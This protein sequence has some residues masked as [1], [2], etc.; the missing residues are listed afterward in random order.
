MRKTEDRA[1]EVADTIERFVDGI[2]GRWDW[3]DFML[4]GRSS[5]RS[6]I[7]FVRAAP[8]CPRSILQRRK[9]HYCSEAGMEVLRQMV[10]RLAAAEGTTNYGTL[11]ERL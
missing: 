3:D 1:A 5:I 11:D 7:Q 9:G 6:S 2:C 8:A 10:A 4:R